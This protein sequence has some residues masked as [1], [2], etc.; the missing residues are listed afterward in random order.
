MDTSQKTFHFKKPGNF[1]SKKEV[2]KYLQEML[3]FMHK[4]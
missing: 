2:H 3:A 1:F 4:L